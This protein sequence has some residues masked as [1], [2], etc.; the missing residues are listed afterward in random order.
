[1][2]L[3]PRVREALFEHLRAAWPRE[4]CGVVVGPAD[5]H[6]AWRF[7]A[8][9]NLQDQLHAADPQAH[10]RDARTAWALDPLSLQE[11]LA[12]ASDRTLV[13]IAHSHP[14]RPAYFS[15]RD[16]RGAAP[17]GTPTFPEAVHL[18]ASVVDGQIRALRGYAWSDG[19]WTEVALSG[20]DDPAGQPPGVP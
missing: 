1:M 15:E 3:P 17:W 5:T 9:D 4:G 11:L 7:V 19:D 6:D 13:A 8:F 20:V 18:V 2:Q 10:P 16:A 14:Q 12:S